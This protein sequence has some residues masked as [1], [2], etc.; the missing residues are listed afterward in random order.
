MRIDYFSF[1][2][3][4]YKGERFAEEFLGRFALSDVGHGGR[5]FREL[6]DGHMSV[7]MYLRPVGDRDYFHV[8]IPGQA[9]VLL[10]QDGWFKQFAA[11]TDDIKKVGKQTGK[12]NITRIDICVDTYAFAPEEAWEERDAIITR[13]KR[14]SLQF[15]TSPEQEREDGKI[16]CDTFYVGS[17]TSSRRLRVYNM[18]GFTR[19]ELQARDV[20]AAEI[21]KTYKRGG[22]LASHV[23]KF[24]R[25]DGWSLWDDVVGRE[26]A[27]GVVVEASRAEYEKSRDWVAGQIAPTL[28]FLRRYM[29]DHQFINFVRA[30]GSDRITEQHF[31]ILDEKRRMEQ[32]YLC[33]GGKDD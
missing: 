10:W 2:V 30:K 22:S 8:S 26:L 23:V 7:K 16:G 15:Y 24:V 25:F 29:G 27:E 9:C 20:W 12:V 21:W 3:H 28:E 5:G 19:I 4:N 13:A 11:F 32:S 33:G 31:A 1:T 14:S 6:R 18:H 17:S